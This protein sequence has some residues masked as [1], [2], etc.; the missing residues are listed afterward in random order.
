M[1]AESYW[2]SLTPMTKVP[3]MFLPGA[4]RMTFLAPASRWAL[5]LVPSVKKPVDSRT[6]STPRSA[7]GRSA[8][9]R[10]ART[11]IS[12]PLTT[13]PDSETATSPSKRPMMESYLSRWAR[14]L[15]SVR[16]LIATISKPSPWAWAAR[17]KVRPMRPKPLIA[18]RTVTEI[19]LLDT[20]S[21]GGGRSAPGGSGLLPSGGSLAS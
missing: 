8:G 19:K 4:E 14:V 18:T 3:S 16:S 13:R 21:D 20:V 12:L 5:A 15:T 17:K 11:L 2:S 7:Q 10:S 9:L 6:T 1:V